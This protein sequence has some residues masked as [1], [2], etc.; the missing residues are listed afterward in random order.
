MANTHSDEEAALQACMNLEPGD[1]AVEEAQLRLLSAAYTLAAIVNSEDG[2]DHERKIQ[3][4]KLAL[5]FES[6]GRNLQMD[7]DGSFWE[8]IGVRIGS[9]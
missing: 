3:L 8:L 1:R 4:V 7:E 9:E 6:L 5:Y 2:E